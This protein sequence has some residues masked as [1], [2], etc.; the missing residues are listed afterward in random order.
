MEYDY[1]EINPYNCLLYKSAHISIIPLAY[2]IYSQKI[3]YSISIGS[4]LCTSL[5][6][7][8]N[9]KMGMRRNIDIAV[10]HAVLIY[11]SYSAIGTKYMYEHYCFNGLG[12]LAYCLAWYFWH[13]NNVLASTLMHSLLHLLGNIANIY[14]ISG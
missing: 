14:L 9:P 11:H 12:I 8:K 7:W 2:A 6:Y 4:V 13:K 10:V 5:I 1:I 3:G